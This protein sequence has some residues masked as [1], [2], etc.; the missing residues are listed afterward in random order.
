MFLQ[1]DKVSL[2]LWKFKS[3]TYQILVI[4]CSSFGF[5]AP[6]TLNYLDFQYFDFESHLMTINERHLMTVIERHLMM[7][8]ERHMMTV[9]E[10]H[11]MTVIERHLITLLSAT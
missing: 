10:R 8:I 5:I 2:S 6:K 7:V 1:L 11:L 3:L 4:L 9:I